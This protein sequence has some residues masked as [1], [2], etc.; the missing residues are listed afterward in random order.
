MNSLSAIQAEH[1]GEEEGEEEEWETEMR[2]WRDS[3]EVSS[4]FPSFF[5][6]LF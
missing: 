1:G 4:C 6:L 5:F 3:E 2:G